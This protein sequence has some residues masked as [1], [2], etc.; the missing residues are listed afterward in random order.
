MSQSTYLKEEDVK[1]VRNVGAYAPPPTSLWISIHDGNPLLTGANEIAFSRVEATSFGAIVTSDI[2]RQFPISQSLDF[3]N[4]PI[5]GTATHVG[6]WDSPLDGNFLIGGEFVGADGLPAPIALAIANDVT[7]AAGVIKISYQLGVFSEYF[8]DAKLNWYQGVAFPVLPSVTNP[9][10]IQIGTGLD[11]SGAGTP[12]LDRQAVSWGSGVTIANYIRVSNDATVTI[13]TAPP[14]TSCN[15]AAFY[16]AQANGNL[17]WA[18]QY[19]T[20]TFLNE[21][22]VFFSA[23]QINADF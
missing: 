16:D 10:F 11:S 21:S 17:L 22:P 12:F 9:I 18:S 6:V 7:I 2:L 4:S 8:I 20:Q 3:I 1:W 5:T 19:P 23:G 14:L 13:G 15:S